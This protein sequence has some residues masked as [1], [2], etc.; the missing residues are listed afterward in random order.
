M[1]IGRRRASGRAVRAA[2]AGRAVQRLAEQRGGGAASWRAPSLPRPSSP[3]A[4]SARNWSIQSSRPFAPRSAATSRSPSSARRRCW[5]RS[6]LRFLPPSACFKI[7][8]GR[9]SRGEHRAL[10][11]LNERRP[12]ASARADFA[13]RGVQRP[14]SGTLARWRNSAAP[15]LAVGPARAARCQNIRSNPLATSGAP[16]KLLGCI[17]PHTAGADSRNRAR[18]RAI[19]SSPA[20]TPSASR[21]SSS[22]RPRGSNASQR[23]QQ[24]PAF[25]ERVGLGR[26]VRQRVPPAD[27]LRLGH[28]R[29]DRSTSRTAARRLPA[30]QRQIVERRAVWPSGVN[31]RERRRAVPSFPAVAGRRKNS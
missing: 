1:A 12:A 27:L 24:V 8:L 20:S 10:L 6:S 3:R 4:S 16:R 14:A 25:V 5:R 21:H 17:Q 18:S 7:V 31:F 2:R 29:H 22:T 19:G 23:G 28:G 9:R 11:A 13:Q 15:G 30:P 26:P